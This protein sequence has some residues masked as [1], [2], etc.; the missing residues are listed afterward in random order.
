MPAG[1]TRVYD[2]VTVTVEPSDKYDEVIH[3][4]LPTDEVPET[5]EEYHEVAEHAEATDAF[6]ELVDSA[7]TTED[8]DVDPD[9]LETLSWEMLSV[10]SDAD[11]VAKMATY[12]DGMDPDEPTEKLRGKLR[13]LDVGVYANAQMAA[14]QELRN[15]E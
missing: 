1:E 14:R 7:P 13:M 6:Q 10:S 15:D 8:L 11:L 5:E 2:R 4:E 3:G 9:E 12:F